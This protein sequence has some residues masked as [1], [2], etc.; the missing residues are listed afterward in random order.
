MPAKIP[1]SAAS[2]RVISIASAS[3]IGSTWSTRSGY[4]CGITFP[5]HPWIR[6]GPGAPPLI[7]ADEAGSCAWMKTPCGLSASDTPISEL[8]VPI[9]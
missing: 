4:Q 3:P 7:A 9:P 2:R 6:N 8:A 5:V 1:S